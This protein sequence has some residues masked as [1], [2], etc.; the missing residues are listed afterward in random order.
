MPDSP[1]AWRIILT[2]YALRKTGCRPCGS[3][4]QPDSAPRR[5]RSCTPH[6]PAATLKPVEHFGC[7]PLCLPASAREARQALLADRQCLT[8]EDL[9][10]RHVDHS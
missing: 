2:L 7:L 3:W 10:E 5:A 6:R 8:G 9:S 4:T 1:C